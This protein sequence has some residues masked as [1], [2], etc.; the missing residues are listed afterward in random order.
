MSRVWTILKREYLENVRTKAFIIGLVLTPVWM[1]LIFVVPML[2]EGPKKQKVVIVD[3]TGEL[4]LPLQ[5]RLEQLE[6]AFEVTLESADGAW[7]A[8]GSGTSRID[9][10]MLA[11]GEGRLMAVVLTAPVLEKRTIVDGEHEP[12]L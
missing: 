10:L 5:T 6:N 7:D 4:A 1:G 11:A 2:Q 9:E 8:R 12:G 3:E